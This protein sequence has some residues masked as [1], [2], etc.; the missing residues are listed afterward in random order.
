MLFKKPF[1][2]RCGFDPRRALPLREGLPM[3]LLSRVQGAV[4]RHG[5][6]GAV[7]RG[8]M[9]TSRA[10]GRFLYLRERHVWYLLDLS[11]ERFRLDLPKRFALVRAGV[12][13]L[14]FL[15]QLPTVGPGEAQRR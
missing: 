6:M 10:I 7:Q 15:K 3:T 9:I 4:S 11:R 14:P 12:E 8:L 1:E 5:V 2:K 13:E